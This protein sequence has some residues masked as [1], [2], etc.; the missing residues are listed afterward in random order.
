MNNIFNLRRFGLLW[1]K[2]YTDNQR[3]LLITLLFMLVFPTVAWALTG[4][5]SIGGILLGGLIF[6]FAS[7]SLL[8]R[9]F[10][11]G[12]L[13]IGTLMLPAS[14]FEKYLFLFLNL[15][16]LNGLAL[17]IFRFDAQLCQW[18][19]WTRYES[20]DWG[21]LSAGEVG[22]IFSFF[23][24]MHASVLFSRIVFRRRMILGF[25]YIA[26]YMG[27]MAKLV[28]GI[29]E[30]MGIT[31]S[32]SG[33]GNPISDFGLTLSPMAEVPKVRFTYLVSVFSQPLR[34]TLGWILVWSQPVIL[35]VAAYFKLKESQVK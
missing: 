11:R 12:G 35:W 26:V 28:V 18:V 4:S 7:S 9:D 21:R 3:T 32:F 15:I 34:E 27:V 19:G 24:L 30:W 13:R 1:V 23:A 16:V 33:T 14:V 6:V 2:Y 25:L 5:I 20:F 10:D 22:L 29:P 31:Q 17:L 8:F